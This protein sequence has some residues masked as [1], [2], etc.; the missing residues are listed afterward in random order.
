MFRP[1]VLAIIRLSLNLS[2]NYTNAGDSGPKHVVVPNVV[3]YLLHYS[4][5]T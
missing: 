3:V 1:Y 2:N 5:K 4:L